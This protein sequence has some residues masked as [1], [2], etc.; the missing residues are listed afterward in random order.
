MNNDKKT[1][2]ADRSIV[3]FTP[4]GTDEKIRLSIEMVKRLVAVKTRSGKTCSDEDAFKFML[5]CKARHLNPF[6][7]DAFLIGYDGQQGPTFSLITAHQAFLK[8]AELHNEFNGMDSGVI[9]LREGTIQDLI[10]DFHMPS[11]KILGGWA[12][13]YFKHREYP[14]RKRLRL[15]RF[16]KGFGVWKEDPAGM[17]VKCAEADALRSSFPTMLGGMYIEQET[18]A[19]PGADIAKPVFDTSDAKGEVVTEPPQPIPPPAATPP[20][21]PKVTVTGTPQPKKKAEPSSGQGGEARPT[22]SKLKPRKTTDH[23]EKRL[24]NHEKLASK[25][26]IGN[27]G[28]TDLIS[29]ALDNGWID[30]SET[31]FENISEDKCAEFLDP[32][33][34]DTI[35]QLLDERRAAGTPAAE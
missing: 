9:V 5:M 22:T 7:G 25:L 28:P 29:I 32:E 23:G 31:K 18:P 19:L 26:A 20:P 15:D 4:F 14:M 35:M 17:I 6:E 13:V 2:T 24:P 16:N 3:E 33:N 21:T 11:D 34:W 10:G 12:T 30:T 27:Y 1:E 8:R